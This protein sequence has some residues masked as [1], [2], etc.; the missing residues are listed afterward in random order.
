MKRATP[1]VSICIGTYNQENYIGQC[2]DS[3]LGQ[4]DHALIEIIVG[5]DLSQ[6]STRE[7]INEYSKNFPDLVFPVFNSQ[8]L[9]AS[10]N[11]RR[12]MKRA[13]GKYIAQL[14]GD[15]Y[16]LPGKLK[17][18]TELL[19]AQPTFSAALSN[20]LVIDHSGKPMGFFTSNRRQSFGLDYLL[21]KGNFL[22]ASTILYRAE[23]R[24]TIQ[25]TM[26]DF[27]DYLALIRLAKLGVLGFIDTPLAVYRWNSPLSMRKSLN[28]VVANGYWMA[29]LEGLRV[30]ASIAAFHSV[31]SRF[32]ARIVVHALV[33]GQPSSI[34]HWWKKMS[35][36]SS[37]SLTFTLICGC[38]R[39]PLTIPHVLIRKIRTRAFYG[40]NS[41]YPR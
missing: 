36:E 39:A 6:D 7:I 27:I 30:G 34:V 35:R 22:C 37:M 10:E 14:D 9:G 1:L 40:N 24:D 21:S 19:E 2:L 8:N 28:D 4:M 15:D 29:L 33:S 12:I 25:P 32:F 31:T 11:Y 17:Q 5:D 16:W 23:Y 13:R 3:V 18:Q 20:A 38:M 41:F 26:G